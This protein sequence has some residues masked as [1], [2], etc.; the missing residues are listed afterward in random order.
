M[1]QHLLRSFTLAIIGSSAIQI[2]V[3]FILPEEYDFFLA[4]TILSGSATLV[5]GAPIVYN[6][7]DSNGVQILE[8]F[9]TAFKS[10]T[11]TSAAYR[12]GAKI[13]ANLILRAAWRCKYILTTHSKIAFSFKFVVHFH[14]NNIIDKE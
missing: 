13:G 10:S 7:M 4:N 14:Y 5:L 1:Q 12:A 3:C 2:G 11:S 8:R 6:M 9:Q